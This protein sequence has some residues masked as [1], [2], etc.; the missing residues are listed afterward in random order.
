M[1]KNR[2]PYLGLET[3]PQ[4][5]YTFPNEENLCHRLSS[6]QP[7]D[8]HHQGAYCLTRRYAECRI[9]QRAALRPVTKPID[10]EERRRAATLFMWLSGIGLLVTLFTGLYLFDWTP[11]S[12]VLF[13]YPTA[14]PTPPGSF[15]FYDSKGTP[16]PLHSTQTLAPSPTPLAPASPTLAPSPTK[17]PSPTETPLPPTATQAVFHPSPT[18]FYPTWTP[19]APLPA[20]TATSTPTAAATATLASPTPTNTPP[21]PTATATATASPSP[22]ATPQ[23]TETPLPTATAS[24]APTDTPAPTPTLIVTPAGTKSP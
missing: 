17:E 5:C 23:P 3:D 9:F 11:V 15:V 16:H 4:T 19:T 1:T 21:S 14:T 6:P 8:L 18:P 13:G 2:C 7:I 24:P 22:S 20:D 12:A 10:A